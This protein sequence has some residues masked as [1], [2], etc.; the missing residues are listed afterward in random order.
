ME[1]MVLKWPRG[2][3]AELVQLVVATLAR[4][5]LACPVLL[6]TRAREQVGLVYVGQRVLWVPE[7]EQVLPNNSLRRSWE[8]DHVRDGRAILLGDCCG[9]RCSW[10]GR[11]GSSEVERS[12]SCDG[13]VVV[14]HHLDKFFFLI[15][16]VVFFS[17]MVR[18]EKGCNGR[19]R[20]RIF[21]L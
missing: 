18:E 12:W 3:G 8:L 7:M 11:R 10:W 2:H 9:V 21:M 15:F 14:S 4:E 1:G 5:P 19:S 16:F 13:S 6:A 20:G 17:L